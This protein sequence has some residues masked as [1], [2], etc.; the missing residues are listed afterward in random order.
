M[1]DDPSLPVLSTSGL[2]WLGVGISGM[3]YPLDEQTVVK[4][5]PKCDNDYA[6]NESLQDLQIER[7]VYRHLGSHPR[8]CRFISSVQRGIV[9]ERFGE[10]LRKHLL[11]LH[12]QRKTPSRNQALKWSI[13]VAEGVAYLHQK[14]IMQGDIGCH[15]ILL[16]DDEI[17]LCDFGGSSIDGKPAEVGYECR[18]QRW[19][20]THENPS[21]QN[22][23]FALG[24]TIYEIW[25]TTR[26]YQDEPDE[27]VEQNY[28]CQC[29]PDVQ[30]LPVA[31]VIQNCWHGTYHSANEVVA[32]LESL[33]PERMRPYESTDANNRT[34][35]ATFASIIT[36]FILAAWFEPGEVVATM[37]NSWF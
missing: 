12:K 29:F 14:N 9:L 1:Q 32:A 3:V 31:K 17:K 22:E 27:K 10:P 37:R 13:Q 23:L 35:L 30:T 28:K 6:S 5:A 34:M 19:D 26:P 4:I 24:S 8:I 18:S 11:E 7:S 2:K 21:I 20:D 25:T 16:K 33:Q 36:V 15:N